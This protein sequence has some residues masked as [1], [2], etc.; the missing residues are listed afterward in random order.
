VPEPVVVVTD[1]TKTPVAGLYDVI[2]ASNLLF[3]S[4][5]TITV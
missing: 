2:D 4:Y 1:K 3:K 5:A